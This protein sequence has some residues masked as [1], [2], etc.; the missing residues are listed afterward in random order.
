MVTNP[1]NFTTLV[2]LNWPMM[3]ASCSNF[4]LSPLEESD[5]SILTAINKELSEILHDAL[6]TVP[7]F[8]DPRYFKVL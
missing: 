4:T 7:K 2:W 3:A 8:P 1:N 5:C 6:D